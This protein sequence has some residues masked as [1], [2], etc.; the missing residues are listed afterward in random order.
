MDCAPKLRK[1]QKRERLSKKGEKE[2]SFT[3]PVPP[4]RFEKLFVFQRNEKRNRERRKKGK[5]ASKE[6]LIP[7]PKSHFHVLVIVLHFLLFYVFSFS[8]FPFF[9]FSLFS[10]FFRFFSI[11]L[12]FI[13]LQRQAFCVCRPPTFNAWPRPASGRPSWLRV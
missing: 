8:F 1:N 5:E 11:S 10:S 2:E 12:F 3:P 13:V 9:L 4:R 7:K 6:H